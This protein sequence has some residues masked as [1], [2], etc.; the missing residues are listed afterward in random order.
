[1]SRVITIK[2]ANISTLS[3]ELKAIHINGKQMTLSVFR[4]IQEEDLWT[5]DFK[6]N[7]IPWGMVNYFWDKAP[8]VN[9]STI[10]I[11]WQKGD[12][13]RRTRI[14]DIL[15]GYS[16]DI[17]S[18]YTK[19]F[20]HVRTNVENHRL[21]DIN[22]WLDK[23]NTYKS[24]IYY[25]ERIGCPDS[26]YNNKENNDKSIK[27]KENLL[28]EKQKLETEIPILISKANTQIE[29]HRKSYQQLASLPQLYI[30]A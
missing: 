3:V 21:Q 19:S 17:P 6:L 27:I 16:S 30:A 20:L 4:Q 13:L 24:D 29:N 12:E 15:E 8:Q 26:G 22:K 5:E 23:E 11:V 25:N 10:H 7:G 1:M 18:L 14:S 2:E 9:Q 28:K